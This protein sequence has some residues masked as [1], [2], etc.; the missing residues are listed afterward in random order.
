VRAST[1]GFSGSD[2]T[3]GS[4]EVGTF[5]SM[6]T[7]LAIPIEDG[8]IRFK[9]CYYRLTFSEYGWNWSPLELATILVL[10]FWSEIIETG[11]SLFLEKDA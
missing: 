2:S 3:I 7:S 11:F 4:G 8:L 9:K 10:L 6:G 5:R 1:S